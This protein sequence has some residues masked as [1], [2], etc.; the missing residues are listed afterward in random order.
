MFHL[1][2]GFYY[3]RDGDEVLLAWR[4]LDEKSNDVVEHEVRVPVNEWASA[5]ASTSA[6]GEDVET[7][8]EALAF[9]E[10]P[11][12]TEKIERGTEILRLQRAGDVVAET[13]GSLEAYA[14]DWEWPEQV[15]TKW[16]KACG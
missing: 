3:G 5:V 6:R 11:A 9:L 8:H 13:L 7:Y 10:T 4:G 14:P 2:N 12:E 15:L 1:R 16:R